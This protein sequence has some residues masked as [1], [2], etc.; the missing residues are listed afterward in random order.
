MAG[1]ALAEIAPEVYVLR[2]PVLDV[3]AT[4]VVGGEVAAVV[5]TL[6]TDAQASELLTAVRSVTALPLVIINTHHHFDHCYGNGV[7]ASAS[8]GCAIWAHEAAAAGAAR[9]RRSGWQRAVVRA[10]GC[11]PSPSSPRALAD[12]TAA[13]RRTAPCT[14]SPPWTLAAASLELRHLG[15]GHTDGDL[16]VTRARRAPSC[17]PATWS[18]R[19]RHRPSA[20]PS[21]STGRR[22][23]PPCCDCVGDRD[24]RRPGSRRVVDID[25]VR[26]QHD[27]LTRLAWL[28][29]DGHADGAPARRSPRRRRSGRGR[30]GRRAPRLRGAGRP[31]LYPTPALAHSRAAVAHPTVAPR[32]APHSAH[33][34]APHSRRT[35]AHPIA[36]IMSPGVMIGANLVRRPDDR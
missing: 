11:P 36:P 26:A 1:A 23:S 24:R 16:V 31:Q 12:V 21:R 27:E 33:R 30:A 9:A 29:R 32:R 8:P 5:D 18:S 7:L 13:R 2:Y 6:S 15:R 35:V 19:A 28:I 34:R 17:S 4:L 14:L 10:S 3:N 22:R 20:T 25:F